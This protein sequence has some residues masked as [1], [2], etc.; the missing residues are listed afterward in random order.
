MIAGGMNHK[1]THAQKMRGKLRCSII[2]SNPP[3]SRSSLSVSSVPLLPQFP[4]LLRPLLAQRSCPLASVSF[5]SRRCVGRSFDALGSQLC[6]G[7]QRN[8]WGIFAQKSGKRVPGTGGEEKNYTS[9]CE[10][11][12]ECERGQGEGGCSAVSRPALCVAL[13]LCSYPA[14]SHSQ[15]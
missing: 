3:C 4:L 13:L 7:F 8:V 10:C 15:F 14:S 1:Q 5:A 6:D 12:C 9:E 11:E 2:T